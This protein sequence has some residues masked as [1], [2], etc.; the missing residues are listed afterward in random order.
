MKNFLHRSL[1]RI[2]GFR[3][4]STLFALIGALIVFP[5]SIYAQVVF[6]QTTNADF[7]LGLPDN[8]VVSGDNVYLSTKATDVAN[9]LS[10]TDLPQALSGHQVARWQSY[11]YLSGG[12]NGTSYSDAVYRSTMA[13]GGNGSWTAYGVLPDSLSDH[14]M[15]AGNEYMYILGGR[16]GGAPFD[17]IYCAKINSDG[18]LGNWIESPVSLPQPLWGHTAVFQNGYIYVVGGTGSSSENTALNTVYYAKVINVNGEL[19]PFTA[20]SLLPSARNG[21]SMVSYGNKLIVLGGYDNSG[22]KQNSVYYSNLNLDGTCSSWSSSTALPV[23]ISNHSSTCYNGLLSVVGGEDMGG[24]SDKVY[25][26]D[27]DDLPSPTWTTAADLLYEARKDATAY[28]SDGQIVFAGGEN[29]SALPIHN[30]RYALVSLSPGKVNKGSFLSYPFYQ[31]GEE[32]DIVDLSYSITYNASFNNYNLVYRLA[33]ADQLWGNWIDAGQD[34]PAIVGQHMQYIQYMIRFDGS[35]DDNVVLHDLSVNI[36]GYTQLSGNLDGMDTLKLA[37]SPFWAT[38]DI[39]FTGGDHV[40]E[41]GVEIYFSANTGLEIGQANMSFEGTAVAPILLTSYSSEAGL[42]NGV[43]F[44]TNS[45]NGVSSQMDYVTIE[46]AGNGS[47][48]ANLYCV[49]TNEPQINNCVFS[50]ADG[51][52]VWMNNADLSVESCLFSDNVESGVSIQNS[53]PS[54]SN[55]DFQSNYVAGIHF[56]DVTSNPNFF[57][58][59]IDGNYFGIYYS[60]PNSSFPVIS[61]ILSYNNV[62]SGIAVGGGTISED[63]TWPFNQLGY[64][65]VGDVTIAKQNTP[66]RL[67]IAPGNTI[68][69]DTAVQLQVGNY[70]FYNQQYGGE[71]FAVGKPDSLI[72]FTSI[73]GQSGGWD[74]IYFHYNSDS[75]GSVSELKNCNI[76]NGSSYNVRCE[77]TLQPRIDSCTISNS[78]GM[79]LYVEDP[80]SV[81]HITSSSTTVYVDGGTQNI[82]KTWYNYGGGDYVILDD[83][84]VAKQ[85]SKVTLTIQPGI[86]VK[87]DT[88]ALLQIANY[89][90]YNQ[91]YGGE[92]FAEGT[93]DSLITFT[94]RNGLAGGWDG[95]YFHYNSDAFGSSSSMKYCTVTNGKDFNVKSDGSAEPRIDF[96][97]INNSDGYDIYAVAPNDVQHITNTNSTVYIGA[98]TQSINKK[99][100]YYGGEYHIIGDVIVAKQN[101]TVRLTIEPGNTIRVDTSCNIQVGQYI[102]YNQQYGGELFAEGNTDSLIVFTSLNGLVGGWDGIYFHYNSDSFGSKSSLSYC[103][104]EKADSAN[105]FCENTIEPRI[106]NCTI[107]NAQV[108][109][110]YA[111]NPNSVPHVSNTNST[112]YIGPGTQSIDK[113]WYNYGGEYIVLGDVI[114]AKQNDFCTLTIEAGNTIKYDSSATMQI[115]NY[116]YYNKNYGGEIIAEGAPDSL[117]TFSSLNPI[118]GRWDGIYFHENADNFGGNSSLKYCIV[119]GADTLDMYCDKTSNLDLEHVTFIGSGQTGV[120]VN[121]SSPYFKLCRFIN[122]DSIGLYVTGDSLL[123]VGDTLGYGCDIYGNGGFGI[124]NDSGHPVFARNNFW[125]S[126]D[127]TEIAGRVFDYYDNI[128]KGRV[129]FM[130]FATMSY[131]DNQPPGA[132]DLLSLNDYEVT[133]DQTPSFTW[134][135]P[136]DP[137]NDAV[138]YYFYYTDDSTWSS[139]IVASPEI[140]S[141]AYAVPQTLTGGKW[142]WWKVRASDGF[143]STPGSE[144]WRFA[145]SLPPTVP[146]PIVPSNGD[147]M[148]ADDYLVWLTSSDPDAGDY[149]DHYHLQI[150]DDPA[151]GSPE[152][153]TTGIKLDGKASSLS[154][155]I[156][157]LPGYL[158]LENKNYYWRI[159]AID[160]FGV[161]SDFSDGTDYFLFMLEHT[162]KVFLEGCF[163]G[164]EMEITLN[165]NGLLPLA[166]PFNTAPWNY[167]KYESVGSMPVDVAD[168]VLLE[169]RNGTGDPSTATNVLFRKAALLLKDGT[170][171]D[172]DGSTSFE[173]PASLD[174]NAY[175]AIYH[176]NHLSIISATKLTST[177]GFYENDFTT[178]A[179]KVWGGANGYS[180]IAPGVWGMAVGDVN[181]D[182]SIDVGD[183]NVGWA[184]DAGK[185][186]Y[187]KGDLNMDGQAEN[188]D[189]NEM[190]LNNVGK[191][192]S[193]PD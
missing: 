158:N 118:A 182:G 31:F 127:S 82:D 142:Y 193:I 134:E 66:V 24:L 68:L 54:F 165:T 159:S 77:Q 191:I 84:I 152:I 75:F 104:V 22:V 5:N 56:A 74:G 43:Y 30:T 86:T 18:T 6:T 131:F 113:T 44:N 156:N 2:M 3:Y 102:Y 135:V 115:G 116:I 145:V 139:N 164:S 146:V 26:A 91:Q 38:S 174:D 173:L 32:R 62:I 12:F 90:Y 121:N 167:M 21:H 97:T 154:L 53:N 117:I 61:G 14:A 55:S 129:Y 162:I 57:N 126:N 184:Q 157:D 151:F 1:G 125:N 175:L 58:C 49:N 79:D 108:Y 120:H 7:N 132:F 67:T 78:M 147:Q 105:I 100:Y 39:S 177:N 51:Y 186:G 11:V 114:V 34:N 25:F 29:I 136:T 138:S 10:T 50:M 153:D 59:N 109:D 93:S 155:R 166:Q 176:R 17:K 92:L 190:W 13:S 128:S 96:C 133:T 106:D 160:G 88:S 28:T 123:F 141:A 48:N 52:G 35:D 192:S 178:G 171:M 9:W 103:T 124:Y 169:I 81:P 110:I 183:M 150:D 23:N 71:L 181:G 188:P 101:D 70:I 41:G 87:A 80:N 107:T 45:D 37:D 170:V 16:K 143:L 47:R 130:D 33:G 20:T 94:S 89:I 72:T 36:S 69:F 185:A 95:I 99:W 73:N 148:R 119:D 85:N 76:N 144:T 46:K 83:I 180:E 98:G 65:V 42:W 64:S 15:V 60:S 179:D 187:L 161:E 168:W 137:D 112:I 140:T 19:G 40:V 149:V 63:Q 189:K 122:N 172:L 27:I 4:Y 163:N 8:V 111:L